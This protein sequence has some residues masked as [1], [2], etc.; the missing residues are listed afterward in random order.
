ML[1]ARLDP[2]RRQDWK[3]SD[4]IRFITIKEQIVFVE[5]LIEPFIIRDYADDNM[6]SKL[7]N[8]PLMRPS[9]TYTL[10]RII[11]LY[12]VNFEKGDPTIDDTILV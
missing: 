1:A 6:P 11:D 10:E 5:K 8:D 3:E 7:L 2:N 12:L 9:T 4:T